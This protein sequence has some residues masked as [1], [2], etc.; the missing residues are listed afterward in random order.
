MEGVM[1]PF[2]ETPDG[3]SPAV[4]ELLDQAFTATWRELQARNGSAT[5]KSDEQTT[6]MAITKSIRDL[7]ATGV[8]DRGR[9]TRHGLH[10]AE[11][12]RPPTQAIVRSSE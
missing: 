2:S 6:R 12:T 4:L 9:L 1:A 7:A 11:L 5:S 10:A 3:M 8:R